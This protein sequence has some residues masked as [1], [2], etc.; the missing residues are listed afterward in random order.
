MSGGTKG[1]AWT[2]KMHRDER[3]EINKMVQTLGQ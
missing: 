3:G 1:L 2:G